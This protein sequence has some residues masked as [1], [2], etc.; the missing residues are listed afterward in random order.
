MVASCSCCD[1]VTCICCSRLTRPTYSA[2]PIAFALAVVAINEVAGGAAT[3]SALQTSAASDG[4][5]SSL[6]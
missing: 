3:H 4:Q 2:W 6:R 5:Y 1:G